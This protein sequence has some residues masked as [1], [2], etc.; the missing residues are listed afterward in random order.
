VHAARAPVARDEAALARHN[1]EVARRVN[2]SGLAYVTPA[3]L[4]GKQIIG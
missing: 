3:V 1:L 4:G 2:A